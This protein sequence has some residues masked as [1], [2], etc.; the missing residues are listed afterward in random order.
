MDAA[1][2]WVVCAVCCSDRGV[3]G[4]E[5]FYH[6]LNRI[7]HDQDG[8]ETTVLA[9]E[10]TSTGRSDRYHKQRRPLVSIVR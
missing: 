5:T 3:V 1:A 9:G 2:S 4:V 10:W 6:P 8:G 7:W